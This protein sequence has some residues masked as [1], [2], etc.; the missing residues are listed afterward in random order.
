MAVYLDIKLEERTPA[1]FKS[2]LTWHR[3]QLILAVGVREKDSGF[4]TVHL[5]SQD[6]AGLPSKLPRKEAIQE[7]CMSWHPSLPLLAVGWES[8]EV[9]V[10]NT[11]T[12][13]LHEPQTQH[14]RAVSKI[15]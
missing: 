9:C 5:F 7:T 10:W 15:Q 11:Q 6:G 2:R 1:T 3:E 14:K 13:Q 12:K 4:G 8:G